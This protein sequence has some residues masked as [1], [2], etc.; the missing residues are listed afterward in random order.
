MSLN[1]LAQNFVGGQRGCQ[2]GPSVLAPDNFTPVSL[3]WLLRRVKWKYRIEF[4]PTL[5]QSKKAT[6][7]IVGSFQVFVLFRIILYEKQ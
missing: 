4:S 3:I 6:I 7:K 5:E 1:Q 2:A